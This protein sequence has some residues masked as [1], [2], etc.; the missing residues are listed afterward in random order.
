[1][2]EFLNY[3]LA[4]INA[5]WQWCATLVVEIFKAVWNMFMDAVCWTLDAFY[6]LVV[7]AVNEIDPGAIPDLSQYWAQLPMG[8]LDMLAVIGF[9]EALAIVFAA[10]IIR[11]ILQLIPFIRLGS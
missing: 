1:M 10:L 6:G 11:F 8:M 5:I 3:I 7:A 9:A 2:T 4:K